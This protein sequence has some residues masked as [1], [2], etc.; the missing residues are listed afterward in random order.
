[1]SLDQ[2]AMA[3]EELMTRYGVAAADVRLV[4]SPYRI[5]PLGAHID[6]QLGPVTAMALDRGVVLAYAPLRSRE[7][8]IASLAYPGEVRFALD[9]EKAAWLGA[10]GGTRMDL[11]YGT[12]EFSSDRLVRLGNSASIAVNGISPYWSSTTSRDTRRAQSQR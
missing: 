3:R 6:H 4:L 2:I 1:M 10:A 12:P 9:K 11:G 7:V 8:R 5:C